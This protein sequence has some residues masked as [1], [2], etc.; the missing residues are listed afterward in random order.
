[1]AKKGQSVSDMARGRFG[2][3]SLVIAAGSLAL[4]FKFFATTGLVV[5][6]IDFTGDEDIF[7]WMFMVISIISALLTL[8]LATTMSSE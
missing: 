8:Y 1:M 5:M 7:G 3:M 4:A 2:M 6:Q